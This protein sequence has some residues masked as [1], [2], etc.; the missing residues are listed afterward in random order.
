MEI[1]GKGKRDR[2]Q[3]K[4]GLLRL[5]SAPNPVSGVCIESRA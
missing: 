4:N 1:E 2:K 5:R 3:K